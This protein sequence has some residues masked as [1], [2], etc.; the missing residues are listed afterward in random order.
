MAHN[1]DDYFSAYAKAYDDFDAQRLAAFFYV[2]TLMVKTGSVTALVTQDTL[3]HYLEN[4][5]ES[6]RQHGYYKG[7]IASIE[8]TQWGTWSALV[9]VH[10]IIKRNDASILCDLD[11][12]YNLFKVAE[13]WKILATTNHD[14]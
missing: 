4:L 8:A 6:Y 7:T 5:V 11:S 14:S 12:S 13:N 3:S 9:T 10:W 2:P 1:F